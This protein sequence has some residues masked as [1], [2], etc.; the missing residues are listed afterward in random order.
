MDDAL[1]LQT[2]V[3]QVYGD[4]C[5]TY[6]GEAAMMLNLRGRNRSPASSQ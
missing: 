5:M 6:D 3:A 2:S 4:V 1:G